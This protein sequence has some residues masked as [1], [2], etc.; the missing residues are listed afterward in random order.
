M[1]N[2]KILEIVDH[3]N[4]LLALFSGMLLDGILLVALLVY[5]WSRFIQ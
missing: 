1:M 5:I 4:I 3:D 2:N